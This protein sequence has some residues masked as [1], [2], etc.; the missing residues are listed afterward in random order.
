MNCGNLEWNPLGSAPL[1]SQLAG[2]LAGLVFA[3]IV[4]LF[5]ER[6]PSP[7]RTRALVLLSGALLA[8]ALDSFIFGVVSGEQICAKAWTETMPAGGL[9]GLGALGIF[10]GICWL[11]NAYDDHYGRTTR[12]AR[13][14]TYTV[15]L[16]VGY[17]LQVAA[18]SY[19]NA[20]RASGVNTP[21]SWLVT[22]VNAYAVL[23]VLII[24]SYGA[25]RWL[26]S[27]RG[28]RRTG[29]R[30]GA[31]TGPDG[32]TSRDRLD[33]AAMQAAY[34]SVFYVIVVAAMAGTLFSRT[35]GEWIPRTPTWVVVSATL[36]SLAIPTLALLA[37]LRA[38]PAPEGT[39]PVLTL[40]N[41]QPPAPMEPATQEPVAQDPAAQDP[42]AQDPAV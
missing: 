34:L 14:I 10:G 36:L 8:L 27:R 32:G 29:R 5:S 12:L 18:T 22:V 38:L 33:Q 19:L 26:S 4:V 23:I 31:G 35:A 13:V 37:Q 1:H 7:Q 40:L 41:E 9:L 24:L 30:S 3:G 28:G 6:N 39:G 11:F 25:A 16:I 17:H 2:V 20:L 15:A 21:P 42:V